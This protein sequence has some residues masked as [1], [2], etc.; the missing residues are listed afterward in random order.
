MRHGL[1]NLFLGK[2]RDRFRRD[3]MIFFKLS[4]AFHI[5]L[6]PKTSGVSFKVLM[7]LSRVLRC[8]MSRISE[9]EEDPG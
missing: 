4:R 2:S 3:D 8:E 1:K 7:F 9:C 6:S 5:G